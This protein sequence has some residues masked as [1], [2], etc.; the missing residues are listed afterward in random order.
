MKLWQ[1]RPKNA[2]IGTVLVVIAA[3]LAGM[4]TLFYANP[5]LWLWLGH[6]LSLKVFQVTVIGLW[7]IGPPCWFVFETLYYQDGMSA[8]ILEATKRSQELFAKV[9][10]AVSVLLGFFW[11]SFHGRLDQ[12]L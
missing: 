10:A 1:G 12:I 2:R 4:S 7:A 6:R 5:H 3:M 11:S 8:E 9:W